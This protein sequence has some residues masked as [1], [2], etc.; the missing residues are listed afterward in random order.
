MRTKI[1]SDSASNLFSL[2]D[3]DYACV[4]L[5]INSPT[6]E[7]IDT[8]DLDLD[9]MIA[10]LKKAKGPTHTSCPNVHEWAEAFTGADYVFAVTITS[11]LSGSCSAAMQAAADTGNA[12]VVDSLSAGPEMQ[13]I[14][15]KLRD[16]ILEDTEF[17][18]AKALIQDY[19]THTHL[20]FSLESLNNL[21]RNGRVSP[22]VAKI[23]GVL[24]LRLVGKASDHGTL[25]P[26]HKVRGEQRAISTIYNE[27]KAHGYKGKK[28]IISHCMNPNAAQ[29]LAAT[30][31]AD[32]PN[33][34]VN[35][36][37]CT[38]L[39]SFYAEQGGLL[40]GFEDL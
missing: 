39:C 12:Y 27:M 19:Q 25:E 2:S 30:I 14:I 11:N 36:V 17:E 1:V 31:Y 32:F 38:A 40:V 3:V 28:V 23:A 4:P 8:P 37:N 15:E 6:Q 10:D 29:K 9:G 24:G 34:P 18:A 7:Y 13:L 33:A 5:K 21:A 22:A 20:L 26:M 16:L 35:I